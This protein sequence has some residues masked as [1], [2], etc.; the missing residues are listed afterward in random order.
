MQASS[1]LDT[2]YRFKYSIWNARFRAANPLSEV[3]MFNDHALADCA[4]AI[5]IEKA[6]RR[7][8]ALLAE[9]GVSDPKELP[10][11]TAF[12]IF[13]RAVIETAAATFPAANVEMLKHNCRSFG[14]SAFLTAMERMRVSCKSP[15]DAFEMTRGVHAAVVLAGYGLLVAPFDLDAMRIL[16]T[17]SKDIDTVLELFSRD[18]GVYVG[19]SSCK[20]PFYLLLTDCVR[21]LRRLVPDHPRFSEVKELFARANKPLPPDPEQS[22]MHGLAVTARQ[23]GDTISTV[24]LFDPDPT[25]PWRVPPSR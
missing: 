16:T 21:T 11:A 6:E 5:L 1:S 10:P 20:A 17:P 3:L 4:G 2:K 22:F 8:D 24:G 9:H 18:K 25:S 7:L 14:H 15:G 12:E 19:Y 13:Q 23:L